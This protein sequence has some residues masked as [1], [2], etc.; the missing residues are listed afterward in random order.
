M[1]LALIWLG[2]ALKQDSF[3]LKHFLFI[4]LCMMQKTVGDILTKFWTLTCGG[5]ASYPGE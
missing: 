2:L 3:I 4:I 1:S 5:L